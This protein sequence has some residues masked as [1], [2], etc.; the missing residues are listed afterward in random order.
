M[1]FYFSD[2]GLIG[3]SLSMERK[4]YV[5]GFAYCLFSIYVT[6]CCH[7]S[8]KERKSSG[9]VMS[10]LGGLVS[11]WRRIGVI[12]FQKDMYV[13]GWGSGKEESLEKHTGKL[14]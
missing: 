2:L 14:D 12:G 9:E 10:D 5:K 13:L 1:A 6:Y 4:Y 7:R 8:K 3:F 11:G